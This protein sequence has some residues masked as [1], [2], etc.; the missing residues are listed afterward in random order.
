[1]IVYEGQVN[2]DEGLR[3]G[4]KHLILI[5]LF[6]FVFRRIKRFKVRTIKTTTSSRSYWTK[7]QSTFAAKVW[8]FR[9]S[10]HQ[11]SSWRIHF[12]RV[13]CVARVAS[14][15]TTSQRKLRSQKEVEVYHCQCDLNNNA[16]VTTMI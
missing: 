9:S 11:K 14:R 2:R 15:H 3:E 16:E 12:S 10:L 5:Y 1:M 7:F 13:L 8:L 6:H 4:V